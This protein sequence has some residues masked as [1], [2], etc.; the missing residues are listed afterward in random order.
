MKSISRAYLSHQ[1]IQFKVMDLA[2]EHLKWCFVFDNAG[3]VNTKFYVDTALKEENITLLS[4]YK[5][6][7]PKDVS[8]NFI[9]ISNDGYK[10]FARLSDNGKKAFVRKYVKNIESKIESISNSEV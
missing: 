3:W 2:G 8:M 10:S 7:L 9:D 6:L 4:E 5:T 1:W